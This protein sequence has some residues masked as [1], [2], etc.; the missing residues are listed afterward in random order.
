[1]ATSGKAILK[2]LDE[3]K[4]GEYFDLWR[5]LPEVAGGEAWVNEIKDA[6]DAVRDYITESEEYTADE[7]KENSHEYADSGASS[8]YKY[9]HDMNHALSLWASDEIEAEAEELMDSNTQTI[10]RLESLYYYIA[11]R[12]TFCAVVDEAVENAEELE[13]ASA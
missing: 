13:E 12:A 9:I 7:L 8:S 3:I 4:G 6:C 11:L 1:M 2:V 10:K 5:T